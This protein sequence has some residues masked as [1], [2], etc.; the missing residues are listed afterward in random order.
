MYYVYI[1]LSLKDNK[2]YTGK[3]NDLTKRLIRHNKGF[4][5]STKH[6]RPFILIY[7]EKYNSAK[8]AFL[9]EIELKKP[10][11]GKFKNKL[12][13]KLTIKYSPVAQW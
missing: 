2:F 8:E 13:E 6:R 9:R 11:A 4:V 5:R 12:R 10:S 7:F 1:L 3:T